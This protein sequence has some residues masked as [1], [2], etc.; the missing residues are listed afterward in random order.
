MQ[1]AT[2]SAI[3]RRM[4]VTQSIQRPLGI[5]VFGSFVLRVE[6]DTAVVRFTVSR[7]EP[8]PA[9]AFAATREALGQVRSALGD[10]KIPAAD[11]QS[12]YVRLADA[13]EHREQ[14]RVKAGYTASGGLSVR[15]ADLPRFDEIVASVVAAGANGIESTEFVTS[16][17]GE[18]RAEARRG[19]FA[20]ARAKAKLYAEEA[21]VRL[22]EVLH[23]EDVNPSSR[24]GAESHGADA[25][26]G[27][28]DASS[29]AAAPGSILVRGAVTVTFA[30]ERGKRTSGFG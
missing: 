20:A 19:A 26:F 5:N 1:S 3:V 25:D 7:T 16:H 24:R 17:L 4:S 13:Y 28:D 29:L 30:I 15:I 6:P 21:G 23:V 9:A 12:S 2:G 22:G 18:H 27:G 10:A 8:E 11:V 14:R